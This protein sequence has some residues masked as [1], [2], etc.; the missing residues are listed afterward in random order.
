MPERRRAVVMGPRM[1]AGFNLPVNYR[2][3]SRDNL[4]IAVKEAYA[5]SFEGFAIPDMM[6]HP[7]D[8]APHH[9][10]GRLISLPLADGSGERVL[11]RRCIRG[12]I[13]G[14]FV[15]G[16]YLNYGV[17]RPLRELRVSEYARTR[18]IPTPEVLAAAFERVSPLFYKG[19]V[20][21][22]EVSPAADLQTELLAVK[23]SPDAEVLERKRSVISSLGRLVAKMH[24]AGIYH[25]DLHLKNALLYRGGE[26]QDVYV[27]D[28]DD[29]RICEPLSDFR[30]CLNLLRLYRS[31]EKVNRRNRVITR[32]DLFRFLTSYARESSRPVRELARKLER[33]LPL[34]RFK[35]KLSDAL[36]I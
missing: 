8:D 4:D 31:A 6:A 24:G 10:R 3:V 16:T 26:D 7:E 18:G 5:E 19:A 1:R 15:R 25:A 13:L 23:C 27:L 9:G 11:V 12:G 14:R 34:W 17:P 32:T 36:G 21:I 30:K 28:L 20:A 35:W 22:R 29:A 2:M 33:M